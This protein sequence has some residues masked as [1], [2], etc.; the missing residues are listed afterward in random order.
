MDHLEAELDVA[1][2]EKNAVRNELRRDSIRS[3]SLADFQNLGAYSN[4]CVWEKCTAGRP[5]HPCHAV[6]RTL[7]GTL[8]P[9]G[10]VKWES[11]LRLHTA[12]LMGVLLVCRAFMSAFGVT[13]I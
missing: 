8:G 1:P 5:R 6:S 12:L 11:K 10:Q 2:I 3:T 13:L 9:R 4:L 7:S